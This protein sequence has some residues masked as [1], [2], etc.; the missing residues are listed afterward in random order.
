ME[1]E[2]VEFQLN[3]NNNKTLKIKSKQ[4]Q[5]KE[6]LVNSKDKWE[7]FLINLVE[8]MMLILLEISLSISWL[9][10]SNSC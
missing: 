9:K 1:V 2:M 8:M 7:Q 6:K 3:N 4:D 10:L 5:V